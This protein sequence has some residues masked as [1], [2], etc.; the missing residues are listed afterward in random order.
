[1]S[2][3]LQAF[4]DWCDS[5]SKKIDISNP[6]LSADY[7]TLD[8]FLDYFRQ[9]DILYCPYEAFTEK[10]VTSVIPTAVIKFSEFPQVNSDIYQKVLVFFSKTIDMIANLIIKNNFYYQKIAKSLSYI[11]SKDSSFM[12]YN[13]NARND[14]IT[15]LKD[16]PY[17]D[18]SRWGALS[19]ISDWKSFYFICEYFLLIG[20]TKE[21]TTTFQ[22]AFSLLFLK[23]IDNP[24]L[25]DDIQYFAYINIL[26]NDLISMEN[27]CSCFMNLVI[28]LITLSL[29]S[30]S[31]SIQSGGFLLLHNLYS[32]NHI[33][34]EK[35]RFISNLINFSQFQNRIFESNIFEESMLN[36][37][38]L[39]SMSLS[40]FHDFHVKYISSLKQDD[41]NLYFYSI[42]KSAFVKYSVY[43]RVAALKSLLI[44][45]YNHDI[46]NLILIQYLLIH[47][48]ENLNTSIA[49]FDEEIYPVLNY[50]IKDTNGFNL[51]Q[52]QT[53]HSNV[54]IPIINFL[55][56]NSNLKIS[57]S[58]AIQILKQNKLIEIYDESKYH[59][60]L[61]KMDKNSI[62][63]YFLCATLSGEVFKINKES[64]EV[65]WNIF[66]SNNSAFDSF[67]KAF[68]KRGMNLFTDDGSNYLYSK[69]QQ[70]NFT[71]AS[72][73]LVVLIENFILA[74]AIQT[75]TIIFNKNS[76]RQI[77]TNYQLTSFNQRGMIELIKVY[78]NLEDNSEIG[79]LVSFSKSSLISLWK[80]CSIKNV[81]DRNE[82]L[83]N[84]LINC[85][86]TSNHFI[87]CYEFLLDFL[88]KCQNCIL[89]TD[90]EAI[91]F[92]KPSTKG[93][94][95][96]TFI[97]KDHNKTK[98]MYFNLSDTIHCMKQRVSIKFNCSANSLKFDNPYENLSSNTTLE[99][100]S[101]TNNSII[102]IS[103]TPNNCE[104][105]FYYQIP[106]TGIIFSKIYSKAFEILHDKNLSNKLGK[107]I[108]SFLY[109][110]PL[111]QEIE[112]YA[113]QP[114]DIIKVIDQS[115][116][117]YEN[118]VYLR[119]LLNALKDKNQM[120]MFLNE[121]FF[122]YLVQ[123][124]NEKSLT[125]KEKILLLKSL[126]AIVKN[127]NST[128]LNHCENV[129]LSDIS[130]FLYN[131]FDL[132][133]K[134][135]QYPNAEKLCFEFLTVIHTSN[136]FNQEDSIFYKQSKT[137]LKENIIAMVSTS[138]Q[139]NIGNLVKI[140]PYKNEIFNILF[141]E[142]ENFSLNDKQFPIYFDSLISSYDEQYIQM[143][144]VSDIAFNYLYNSKSNSIVISI[145]DFLSQYPQF[146]KSIDI[147]FL[148]KFIENNDLS[149]E[150][151]N[152]IQKIYEYSIQSSE[153]ERYK[154]VIEKNIQKFI[155]ID[156]ISNPVDLN[157]L[158]LPK[159][160]SHAGLINPCSICYLNSSIQLLFT[161]PNFVNLVLKANFPL[162]WQ[163]NFQKLFAVMK[164]G[165]QA[166]CDPMIFANSYQMNGVTIKYTEQQDAFEFLSSIF[167]RLPITFSSLFMGKF[168]YIFDG[169][170]S[171]FHSENIESFSYITLPIASFDNL[172]D[173]L[174]SL[175][176]Y[177][178]IKEYNDE[179][180]KKKISIKRRTMF[181]SLPDVLII[182][183][184][185]FYFNKK[186]CT[187]EKIN[188][189]LSFPQHLDMTPFTEIQNQNS[190]DD[191][192]TN[193]SLLG[194]ILHSGTSDLGH[195][196]YIGY[197]YSNK[198]W[199]DFNDSIVYDIEK[200]DLENS[201]G[202]DKISNENAYILLYIK[203]SYLNHYSSNK[204]ELDV[205]FDNIPSELKTFIDQESVKSNRIK[206]IFSKPFYNLIFTSDN[207]PLVFTY[208]KDILI[209]LKEDSEMFSNISNKIIVHLTQNK[210]DTKK[211]I[212]IIDKDHLAIVRPLVKRDNS[213]INILWFKL[214][215]NIIKLSDIGDCYSFVTIAMNYLKT[216]K[217]SIK[218]LKLIA[219]L[220]LKLIQYQEG[221]AVAETQKWDILIL[222][223][224][225]ELI[226]RYRDKNT[227][228]SQIPNMNIFYELLDSMI[229]ILDPNCIKIIDELERLIPQ[230]DIK[231]YTNLRIHIHENKK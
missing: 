199:K 142:F 135:V 121:S 30:S 96:I 218:S 98:D 103:Y 68:Q 172:E 94:S 26:L 101:I 152:L 140:L 12:V 81:F 95:K 14:L 190:K 116:N 93:L 156:L 222:E 86:T 191:E 56:M 42:C 188:S 200:L 150:V 147:E 155:S 166:V 55:F 215:K 214:L 149:F 65:I 151:C 70:I 39:V 180:T 24:S 124:F 13:T 108:L 35:K 154:I 17:L 160:S 216:F 23:T 122:I 181:L 137:L 3:N 184:Q 49:K 36:I 73:N 115:L 177:E 78:L 161:I 113:D 54:L 208:L 20:K 144:N 198:Q 229:P 139:K 106:E 127:I 53:I 228:D 114:K 25:L 109:V 162:E 128:A 4:N 57:T 170:D 46:L 185:R 129:N 83:S 100:N 217:S 89:L 21:L 148:F 18:L 10:F 5:I 91:P 174:M 84:Y 64:I 72:M 195:F 164:Y 29:K 19:S 69:I 111:S 79:S 169:I 85:C 146:Y 6:S 175:T 197:D 104:G 226:K 225:T 118:E 77:P 15:Y 207:Y 8:Q 212:E 126:L 44:P 168:L 203:N 123:K 7:T 27:T 76:S 97:S 201:F 143:S 153:Y 206:C 88:K 211:I 186:T 204:N 110:L 223:I 62:N 125:L 158:L 28:L 157:L 43:E 136:Y 178:F 82:E 52:T 1:M 90:T 48:F 189:F 16:R 193:Y 102:Q 132:I 60:L 176:S 130:S 50:L 182:Q 112:S 159:K 9:Y 227:N 99:M 66:N 141:K 40:D 231:C 75:N 173:S 171:D 165:N 210:M 41:K 2:D 92:K 34:D 219:S 51:I 221:L 131:I 31:K 45:E 167:T 224:I 63:M 80:N 119:V 61:L 117:L 58:I 213:T 138:H 220:A 230:K 202:S 183:L 37:I 87:R 194:Y 105:L 59:P 32:N 192:S 209:N 205:T 67:I 71:N 145:S 74:D 120:K 11:T 107:S 38:S 163:Q 179:K 187:K 196:H 22:P 33:N 134:N 47:F 133:I